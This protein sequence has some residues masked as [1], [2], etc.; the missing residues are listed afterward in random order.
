MTEQVIGLAAAFFGHMREMSPKLTGPLA[1]IQLGNELAQRRID[2]IKTNA[3][4]VSHRRLLVTEA[5]RLE[6]ESKRV[7]RQVIK[8]PFGEHIDAN[9]A[10]QLKQAALAV[11]MVAMQT[12]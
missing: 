9:Y 7:S 5:R 10:E 8:T 4:E 2:F 12:D 1:N 6:R 11:R 3:P